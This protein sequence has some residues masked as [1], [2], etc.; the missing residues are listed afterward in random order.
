MLP[1]TYLGMKS[2]LPSS[3]QGPHE[4]VCQRFFNL[5]E[6]LLSTIRSTPMASHLTLPGIGKAP[7]YYLSRLGFI[8]K[9]QALDVTTLEDPQGQL[10][11]CLRNTILTKD[12]VPV[13]GPSL[14]GVM[15]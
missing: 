10:A 4:L 2:V 13:F 7:E 15:A 12:S 6:H 9:I 5:T 3:T 14:I 1:S 11:H 8:S